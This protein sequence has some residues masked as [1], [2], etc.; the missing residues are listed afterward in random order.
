[1]PSAKSVFLWLQRHKEFSE[2]YAIAMDSRSDALFEET[3]DIADDGSNDWMETNDPD[4][5]GYR[6]NGEHINRSRLRVDTRKWFISKVK[7]KKYG[8]RIQTVATDP[9]G[10]AAP[11]LSDP[12]IIE[13]VARRLA[14]VLSGVEKD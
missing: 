3:I 9:D 8:D 11:N 2:Q 13:D 14:F 6:A 1:M 10:N 7:P 4:N 12:K 5:P